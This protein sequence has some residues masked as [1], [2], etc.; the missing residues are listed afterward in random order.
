[1]LKI[2]N[3]D[4]VSEGFYESPK[5]KFAKGARCLSEALG[6]Q[7]LSTDLNQRHPFDVEICRV[8]AGK[9]LCP[10]HL[11]SAQWEFYHV[12]AGSGSVRH[13]GGTDPIKTGDA[14]VF[15][16]GEPHQIMGGSDTDL[17]LYVVADNPIGDSCHYP[18]SGKWLVRVPERRIVRSENLD[19]FDGEE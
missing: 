11:H 6:R 16:P 4:D 1:M 15:P 3:T 12:I 5:G 13:S 10:Y 18:D 2:I 8:P 9:A 17:T 14:F 7:P 19:Y